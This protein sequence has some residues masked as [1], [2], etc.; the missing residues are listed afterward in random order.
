MCFP[1]VINDEMKFFFR[2]NY[3][4]DEESLQKTLV[5]LKQ[6]GYSQMQSLFL[7][8]EE[9]GISFKEANQIILDSKAWNS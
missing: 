9:V 3:N 4:N 8:I 1:P 6:M 5:D 2:N 7:L